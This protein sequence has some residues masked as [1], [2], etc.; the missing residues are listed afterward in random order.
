MVNKCEVANDTAHTTR[1]V[2]KPV[3]KRKGAKDTA[4]NE[5]SAH[6]GKQAPSGHGHRTRRA[7]R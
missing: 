6:S 3:N 4:N 2:R 1:Q 7:Q 5:P